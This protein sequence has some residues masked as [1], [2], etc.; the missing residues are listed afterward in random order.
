MK[1]T[2]LQR[3]RERLLAVIEESK[4][5]RVRL[6]QIDVLITMYGDEVKVADPRVCRRCQRTFKGEAG[7]K[8]HEATAHKSPGPRS[9]RKRPPAKKAATRTK[10]KPKATARRATN[11]RR[12]A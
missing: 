12:V 3:E 7:L 2:E 8:R 1:L 6:R 10:A 5:A 11:L 9:G 4:T